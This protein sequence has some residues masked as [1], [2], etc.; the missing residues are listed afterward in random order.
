MD[1][2]SGGVCFQFPLEMARSELRHFLLKRLRRHCSKKAPIWTKTG[3]IGGQLLP[4]ARVFPDAENN[5]MQKAWTDMMWEV[6]LEQFI[7]GFDSYQSDMAF[8]TKYAEASNADAV[9]YRSSKMSYQD[10]LQREKALLMRQLIK[11]ELAAVGQE[12]WDAFPECRD[13]KK[14]P[15]PS[16]AEY[17]PQN[18]PSLQI[19]AG[20]IAADMISSMRFEANDLLDFRHAALAIP[21]CNAVCCDNPMATRLRNKPCEFETVYGTRIFG[22]PDEITAYLKMLTDSQAHEGVGLNE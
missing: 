2:F 1:R 7:E 19:L 5:L 20:I 16:E 22:R 11:D 6:S 9:A 8:W 15:P 4:S 21:Y 13:V 3:F 10:V 17:S 12:L 14:L 18:F